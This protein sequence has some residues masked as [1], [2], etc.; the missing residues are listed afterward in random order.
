MYVVVVVV[1][2]AAIPKTP[3]EQLQYNLIR[4]HWST[5]HWHRDAADA[6]LVE[7]FPIESTMYTMKA[8]ADRSHNMRTSTH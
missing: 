5:R 1:D 3:F 6:M 8:A 2:S 7:D 4:H